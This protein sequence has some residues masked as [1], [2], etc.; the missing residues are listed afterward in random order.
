[1][2]ATIEERRTYQRNWRAANREKVLQWQ[3]DSKD[4]TKQYSVNYYINN[5]EEQRRKARLYASSDR[6]K[7]LRLANKEKYK[8]WEK[9]WKAK[10]KEKRYI[11]WKAYYAT[12]ADKARQ[13]S[14]EWYAKN[15]EKVIEKNNQKR[16][17]M[18]KSKPS[19]QRPPIQIAR[20]IANAIVTR[21]CKR[22]NIKREYKYTVYI[23]C[24]PMQ[25]KEHIENQFQ[26][27]MNWENYGRHGWH[28]DHIKPVSKFDI[29]EIMQINHYTNL[30]PL[31]ETDNMKKGDNYP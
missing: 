4:K 13:R 25:L 20:A 27:G 2:K 21:V 9:E 19:D 22:F 16:L 1:M 8:I 30:Q 28:A 11:R 18:D 6:A 3:K 7:A 10:N 24:T 14:K 29:N 31:W 17:A 5:R 26:G 12:V 15:R 23:G